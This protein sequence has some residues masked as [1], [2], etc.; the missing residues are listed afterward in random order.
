[1]KPSESAAAQYASTT[2]NLTARIAIHSYGTNPQSWFS[3]LSERLPVSGDVLE[4]GAGTGEL[5]KHLAP[6]A[7]R[8]TLVDASPAMCAA[9]REVPGAV[10]HEADAA[11]LPF[12]TGSFDSVIADHMLYHVDDP[13]AVLAEFA[14]VLRPGGRLAVA[15]NG[16]RHM[17]EVD[18]LGR[19]IGR[20]GLSTFTGL[21]KVDT[22]TAPGLVGRVFQDVQVD[23]YGCDLEVPEPEPVL[24][25][26]ASMADPP[27][28]PGEEARARAL[29]AATIEATG[30]FHVTK[31]TA[32]ITAVSLV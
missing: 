27:L 2:G 16:P 9:L 7:G 24:A 29:I 21:S 10:V 32:L 19:A 5:W 3:W 15:L 1:M 30:T 11:A 22:H 13:A 23:P 25:Y 28:T 14:R 31:E 6:P 8:L 4:V 18:A 12:A 20:S 17:S 26:L